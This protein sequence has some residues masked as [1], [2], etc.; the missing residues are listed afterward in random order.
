MRMTLVLDQNQIEKAP[1]DEAAKLDNLADRAD[2]ID[3]AVDYSSDGEY[4]MVYANLEP[5]EWVEIVQ[6]VGGWK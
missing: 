2:E 6:M 4:F 1:N 5:E 3:L